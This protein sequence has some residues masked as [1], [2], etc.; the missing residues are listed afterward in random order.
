[1][2]CI[3]NKILILQENKILISEIHFRNIE[4]RMKLIKL[5]NTYKCSRLD[6]E[7]LRRKC[8]FVFA[9]CNTLFLS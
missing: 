7:C 3:E 6:K 5:Q 8:H 4:K 2:T 1:M 9:L